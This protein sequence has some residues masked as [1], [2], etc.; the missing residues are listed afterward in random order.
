MSKKEKEEAKNL[1]KRQ[2]ESL[3]KEKNSILKTIGV[4]KGYLLIQKFVECLF[5]SLPQFIL[6]VFI[7]FEDV[8]WILANK[9]MKINHW[10]RLPSIIFSLASTSFAATN[11][12]LNTKTFKNIYFNN[13]LE[14]M[15]KFFS[16]LFLIVPRSVVFILALKLLDFYFI[17]GFNLFVFLNYFLQN[18]QVFMK[19]SRIYAGITLLNQK[20]YTFIMILIGL[21]LYEMFFLIR[22]ISVSLKNFIYYLIFYF[23]FIASFGFVYWSDGF[24]TFYLY[25]AVLLLTLLHLVLLVVEICKFN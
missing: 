25:T 20:S 18:R 13:S 24:Y 1:N 15:L 8:D 3:N 17:L 7:L 5:E 16:N 21:C 2:Q 12:S 11:I 19:T 6:Q 4:I 9:R 22:R 14:F 23:I 10:L